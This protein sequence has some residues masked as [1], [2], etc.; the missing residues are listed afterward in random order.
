LAYEP[1]GTSYKY[2]NSSARAGWRR[3]G[4]EGMN[5]VVVNVSQSNGLEGF[6]GIRFS[7]AKG[8]LIF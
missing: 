2:L 1:R 5:V 7:R 6:E 8:V 3:A 4:R